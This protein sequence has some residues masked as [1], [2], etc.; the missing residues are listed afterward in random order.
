MDLSDPVKVSRAMSYMGASG[1][2]SGVVQGRWDGEYEDGKPPGYWTGSKEIMDLW[3]EQG[4][5]PITYGQCWVFACTLNSFMRS[6]GIP[7]RVVGNFNSAHDVP[8]GFM[9]TAYGF[10]ANYD[11]IINETTADSVWNFHEWVNVWFTRPDL[12]AANIGAVVPHA[13]GWNDV[14]STPQELSDGKYQMGP[15]NHAD[16][17]AN[18]AKGNAYDNRFVM[19]EYNAYHTERGDEHIGRY[20]MTGPI[21][22]PATCNQYFRITGVND[23]A[24]RECVNIISYDVKPTEPSRPPMV[25]ETLN[26][27]RD[28]QQQQQFMNDKEAYFAHT[29]HARVIKPFIG[30]SVDI[31]VS[32]HRLDVDMSEFEVDMELVSI[33]YTG[34]ELNRFRQ[35][36]RLYASNVDELTVRVP[37]STYE[38]ALKKSTDFRAD[39]TLTSTVTGEVFTEKFRFDLDVPVPVV[40]GDQLQQTL[41]VS[42]TNPLPHEVH[43]VQ[44]VV[45]TGASQQVLQAIT[46]AVGAHQTYSLSLDGVCATGTQRLAVVAVQCDELALPHAHSSV[47]LPAC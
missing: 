11:W 3:Q 30:E 47:E 43:N 7:A 2:P 26:L 19:G 40:S 24:L 22:P 18:Y 6:L 34:A 44:F 28:L 46:P 13:A 45:N 1:S 4:Q 42:W 37:Y 39:L 20:T 31:R 9:R 17:K 36:Q 12:D 5:E 10:E 15:A 33:E 32:S 29:F 38:Q 14:D 23:F 35:F 27:R 41:Q 25:N 16:M 21:N 8:E